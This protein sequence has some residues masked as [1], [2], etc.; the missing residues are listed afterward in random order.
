MSGFLQKLKRKPLLEELQ[1]H[2]PAQTVEPFGQVLVVPLVS[3]SKHDEESLKRAG[4]KIVYQSH[5]GST[6]AFVSLKKEAKP[7]SSH[8][9]DKEPDKQTEQKSETEPLNKIEPAEQKP[10]KRYPHPWTVDERKMLSELWI[11]GVSIAEISEKLGRSRESVG[12]M[13]RHLPKSVYLEGD[14]LHRLRPRSSGSTKTEAPQVTS[15]EKPEAKSEAEPERTTAKSPQQKP[16]PETIKEFLQA[17]S[18]LYPQ[19]RRASALL[20]KQAAQKME[21][22]SDV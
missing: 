21:T 9:H 13:L 22:A 4:H 15:A 7:E 3:F 12:G 6:C 8:S 5:D 18:V 2:F 1:E 16:D 17:A 14:R 19:Y 11:Q 20:L 10:I